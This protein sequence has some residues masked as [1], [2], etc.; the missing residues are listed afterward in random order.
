MWPQTFQGWT[1][2]LVYKA[3]CPWKVHQW[4]L[5]RIVG[6]SWKNQQTNNSILEEANGN[7]IEAMVIRSQL[8]WSGHVIT[9][10]YCR[11]LGSSAKS[12]GEQRKRFKDNLKASLA[13]PSPLCRIVWGWVYKCATISESK[14]QRKAEETTMHITGKAP[15]PVTTARICSVYKRVCASRIGLVDHQRV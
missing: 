11:Q 15:P 1:K 10:E 13:S 14:R 12:R 2:I 4:Y 3:L 6:V 7:S 8:R 9:M 5:H